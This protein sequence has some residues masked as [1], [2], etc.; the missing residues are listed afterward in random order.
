MKKRVLVVDDDT[1][2]RM[3]CSEALSIAG[4][5]VDRAADGDEALK[6]LKGSRYDLVISDVDMP[7]LDGIGLYL[8]ILKEHPYLRN[9]VLFITGSASNDV[10][11][12]LGLMKQR[13]LVKPFKLS[14]LID[15]AEEIMTGQPEIPVN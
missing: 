5:A 2:I 7:V 11:S 4:C 12:T 6:N 8:S 15:L 10:L 9:R 3:L 13:Y 14:H 1:S